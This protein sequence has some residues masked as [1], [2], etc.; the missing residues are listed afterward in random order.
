MDATSTSKTTE[1]VTETPRQEDGLNEKS[2]SS[3]Q[4]NLVYSDASQE[5]EIHLRTYIAVVAMLLLNYVQIIALQGPPL[6][7]NN[8]GKSLGNPAAQAWIPTALSLVQAVLAPVISSASDTFQARKLILVVGCVISFIGSAVA[9]GSQSIYRLIVAQILIGFGFSSTALAY[10]VPSEILPKKWRPMVQ[11]IVN[12]AAALGACSGPLIMGALSRSDPMNGWRNYYWMQMAM[13]GLTAVSILIG[14]RPRKRYTVYNEMSL[15]QKI[16]ALDLIGV[17]LFAS[18]LTLFLVGLNLGGGQFAW[19]DKKVLATLIIGLVTLLAFIVYEWRGTKV[20]IAHHDLFRKGVSSGRT[21]SLFIALMFIEGIMFFAFSIFYP[22]LTT[23]L[24]EQDPLL[25]AARA[26]PFW[27][28]CGISTLVWGYW[29]IKAKS[30]RVPLSVAFLIFTGGTVG[31]ATIQPDDSL[32]TWFFAGVSGIG[33]GGPLILIITG[34]QLATPHALIATATALAITSRAVSVAVFT[35]IFSIAFTERLQP[36]IASQVPMAALKAGLPVSSV[37]AFV[38]ALAAR[39]MAALSQIQ[40]VTPQII[41]AGIQALKQA[42]A[43]SIRVVFIIAA[44]FGALACLLCW[45][46]DDQSKEMNYRVDAPIEDLH[47][48]ARASDAVIGP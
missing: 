11:S 13:W 30:I 4:V 10:S 33:F 32:S 19:T 1:M 24:F 3:S 17:G 22:V 29:S 42:F 20:G 18:G 15:S 43:D 26:Q 37:E 25:V 23:S 12:I 7:A 48:R 16:K 27:I 6:V 40:G 38:G 45:F 9:P 21:F 8:M 47:A 35:V 28:A 36:N 2:N 31:F 39:D 5:P 41:A 14:Y 34:I 46:L 44:P